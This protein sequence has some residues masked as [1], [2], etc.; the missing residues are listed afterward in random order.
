MKKYLLTGLALLLPLALTLIVIIFLVDL[1]SS[2]FVHLVEEHIF[3]HANLPARLVLV[4]SRILALILLCIF[5]L[6]LGIVARWFIIKNILAGTNKIISRIP[7]IKTIYKV[8]HDIVAALFATDGKKAFQY[9]VSIPFPH[10]PMRALGFQA[11][12]VTEEIK[13]A[14][15]IPLVSVFTP[16]APHPISGF[17]FFIPETDVCKL[18]MT[19]EEALKFLVSCGLIHPASNHKKAS[20]EVF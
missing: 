10:P 3:P 1:F 12:E 4:I 6:L 15:D 5:I 19:N 11:G 14:V 9:P 2:P 20:G 13:Q 18:D 8:S 16:T 17:L 7:F